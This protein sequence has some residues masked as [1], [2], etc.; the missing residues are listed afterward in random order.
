MKQ[1]VFNEIY[2]RVLL[3]PGWMYDI[4]GSYDLPFYLSGVFI[5]LSGAL[6]VVLPLV[7]KIQDM[8]KASLEKSKLKL[9]SVNHV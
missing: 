5:A 1:F 3:V 6:L 7:E 9:P 8:R 2:K 4:T